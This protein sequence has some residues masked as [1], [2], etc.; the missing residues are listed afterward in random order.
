LHLTAN[1]SK[2]LT[3]QADGHIF[4][5]LERSAASFN[6]DGM[7]GGELDIAAVLLLGKGL[8][9]RGTY[10][11]FYPKSGIYKDVLPNPTVANGADPVQFAEL[12]LRYDLMP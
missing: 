9:L 3:L 7:A 11:I 5:R 10:A 1:V 6:Q 12:E 2:A 4:S 8:K